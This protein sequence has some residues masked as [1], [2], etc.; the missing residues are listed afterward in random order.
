MQRVLG[1]IIVL[2][3]W[4]LGYAQTYSLLLAQKVQQV[5]EVNQQL[6]DYENFGPKPTGSLELELVNDWLVSYYTD[7]GYTVSLDSFKVGSLLTS[8][9]IIEKHGKDT[10]QWVVIGA[11]YDSVVDS[12]GAND[13]GTGVVATMQIARLIRDIPTQLSVRIINFGAEE[14]G[15]LGSEHYVANT[16][17]ASDSIAVMFNLDQLGG[18]KS[19]DNS[20]IVCERDEGNRIA[21]ND[22]PSARKT[23]TLAHIFTQYT[24]L[25][26]VLGPAFSTDY[27]PF[28][29][30]G[31]TITGLYQESD[32]NAFYHSSSD[33]LF[34]MDTEATKEVIKGTVAASIYFARPLVADTEQDLITL[35]PNPARNFVRVIVTDYTEVNYV[36][37][38]ALGQQVAKGLTTVGEPIP[39]H[40]CGDG[41][42]TVSIYTTD[43]VFIN[44]SKL[45]IAR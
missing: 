37:T 21:Q 36:I 24:H 28:E 41:L 44:A 20:K 32:Y 27:M 6:L 43:D 33:R 35:V 5:T 13:N 18:T 29:E 14:L 16:L 25:K 23:D 30:R 34:N 42:Y 19:A 2:G 7:L 15:L 45:I 8:N 1:V 17:S 10:T 11:H 12:Y 22:L 40:V 31:Y 9:I 26:P 4:C 38:N 3:S 39:I